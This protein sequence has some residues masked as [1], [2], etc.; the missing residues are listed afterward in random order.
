MTGPQSFAITMNWRCRYGANAVSWTSRRRWPLLRVAAVA[1]NRTMPASSAVRSMI[2]VEEGRDIGNNTERNPQIG[3]T[4]S[5]TTPAIPWWNL[6]R[7]RFVNMWCRGIGLGRAE[8]QSSPSH[9]AK[10]LMPTMSPT[11]AISKDI[12]AGRWSVWRSHMW[13]RLSACKTGMGLTHI[14]SQYRKV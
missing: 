14:V 1:S 6:R 8:R 4:Q 10:H 7:S 12:R 13:S 9:R 2:G 11:T 5:H 3:P